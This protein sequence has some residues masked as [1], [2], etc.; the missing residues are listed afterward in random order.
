MTTLVNMSIDIATTKSNLA[1]CN[2]NQLNV[3]A[4]LRRG[5][6]P[7]RRHKF[8]GLQKLPQKK[9]K[10]ATRASD[11]TNIHDAVGLGPGPGGQT[12]WAGEPE[13]KGART[14]GRARRCV[15]SARGAPNRHSGSGRRDLAPASRQ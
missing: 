2:S 6:L 8:F 7:G 3:Q 13:A 11:L 10:H 15:S 4:G 5:A 14:G 1:A 9:A 12:F